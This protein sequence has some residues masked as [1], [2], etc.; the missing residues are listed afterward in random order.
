[1]PNREGT[2]AADSGESSYYR[3]WEPDTAGTGVIVIC[4]GAAEHC[5]RY[6]PLAEYFNPKGYDLIHCKDDEI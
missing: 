4:H 1:M 5:G 6:E 3:Y 2:F